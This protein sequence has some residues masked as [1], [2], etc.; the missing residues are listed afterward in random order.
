METDYLALCWV[1]ETDYQALQSVIVQAI[2]LY[3]G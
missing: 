1:M 2:R 3:G